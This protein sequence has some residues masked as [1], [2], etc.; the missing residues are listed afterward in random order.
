MQVEQ[1][2]F[3]GFPKSG[4]HGYSTFQYATSSHS[5][6]RGQGKANLLLTAL[7]SEYVLTLRNPL[8][9]DP[10]RRSV[11][12][13]DDRS[14]QGYISATKTPQPAP[15]APRH[16]IFLSFCHWD[17]CCLFCM[18]TVAH[19]LNKTQS[20]ASP[21]FATKQWGGGKEL[22]RLPLPVTHL[23]AIEPRGLDALARQKKTLAGKYAV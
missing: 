17:F 5:P 16:R 18:A 8:L 2:Y 19:S 14:S 6:S 10:T 12:R 23:T 11:R 13:K 1:N 20:K 21:L 4:V 9:A 22:H 3:E 7:G 15:P